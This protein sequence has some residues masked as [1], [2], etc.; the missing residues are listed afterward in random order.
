[1]LSLSKHGTH[2]FRQDKYKL[3]EGIYHI[4]L[5][6]R[7]RKLDPSLARLGPASRRF[8]IAPAASS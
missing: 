7:R 5:G 2:K 1:M 6:K 3:K 4:L 8:Y